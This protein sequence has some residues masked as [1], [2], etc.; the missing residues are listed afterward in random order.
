MNDKQKA[1]LSVLLL[2][3]LSGSTAA[4]IKIGL[5]NIPPLSFAFLRFLIA[6]FIILPVLLKGRKLRSLLPLVPISLLGT[7]NIVAFILGIKTTT[8]TIAQ[9]LYAGVPLLTA[10][11]M[12]TFLKE[13]LNFRKAFG[14]SIGFLGV[15]FVVLLPIFEKGTKFSG[16]LLGN[17]LVTTGVIAWSFYSVFSKNKL[18]SFSPFVM[19]S[20]FILVT[21][22][23]LFP[24]FIIE[25]SAN[26]SWWRNIT[27]S[28]I[29]S[30]VY[31]GT[32]S[33]II[34]YLLN[35]YAIKHGGSIFAS[36]Q[37]YLIPISAYIFAFLLLG[38]ELTTGLVIG[39][40]LALLGVYIT[41]KRK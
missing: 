38:E 5:F 20:A 17:L 3:I 31:V 18:K 24:F 34:T 32:I 40:V 16:D 1:I 33:T 37:F 7:I 9:L 22:F 12:F 15:T 19:T 30:L 8:A 6:G 2:S 25:F 26:S 10:L 4:V 35:Q 11:I 14:I 29:L 28:S 23:V 27:I 39:G 21:C 13:R 36:M 41:T